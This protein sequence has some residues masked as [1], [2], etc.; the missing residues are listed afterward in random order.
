MLYGQGPRA[1]VWPRAI[2]E[3]LVGFVAAVG[4]SLRLSLHAAIEQAGDQYEDNQP[5]EKPSPNVGEVESPAEPA[6]LGNE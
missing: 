2:T 3:P 5:D 6:P 4:R 1:S